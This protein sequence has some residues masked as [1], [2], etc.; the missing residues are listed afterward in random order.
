VVPAC[1]QACPT[2]AIVFGDLNDPGSKVA[3]LAADRRRYD[4]LHHLGTSPR[5]GYL[6]RLRNPNPDLA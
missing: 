5:T 2:E 4:L 6:V 3:R 1:A